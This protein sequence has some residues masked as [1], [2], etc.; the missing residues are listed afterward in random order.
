M[1]DGGSPISM[2]DVLEEVNT[3]IRQEGHHVIQLNLALAM[4][5]MLS[6]MAAHG[7]HA[8]V[9]L[10]AKTDADNLRKMLLLSC[11]RRIYSW[12]KRTSSTVEELF[13]NIDI[14]GS[15]SVDVREFRAGMATLGLKFDDRCAPALGY[16]RLRFRPP[17]LTDFRSDYGCGRELGALVEH[18]DD[19]GD[20][21]LD[22]NEFCLKMTGASLMPIA[23]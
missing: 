2:R 1:A 3:E 23:T 9:S 11:V 6:R 13:T 8:K 22:T 16:F 14:D 7:K 5:G 15:G 12:A 21:V 18:M 19:S 4:G 20:G 17:F 10:A